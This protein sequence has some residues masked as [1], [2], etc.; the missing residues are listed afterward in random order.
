MSENKIPFCTIVICL[1]TL[2]VSSYVAYTVH[3]SVSSMVTIL[4]LNEYG[5]VTLDHLKNYEIWRLFVS[6]LVH[7]HPKHM[8][9]N[10]ASI[11]LLGIFIER[12]IGFTRFLILWFI[13]GAAG[14]LFSTFFV[15]PPFH[16][17]TGASQAVMGIAG[18]GVVL[19]YKKMDTS[20]GLKIVLLITILPVLIIDLMYAHYLKPGHLFGFA[21]GFGLGLLYSKFYSNS[22]SKNTASENS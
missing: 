20:I 1:L 8:L 11:L 17:G 9:L 6:Q 5:G 21:I 19:V 2:L 3:G 7:V 12:N 10:V 18:L 22:L 14:T 15:N 16:V 4:E 13:A